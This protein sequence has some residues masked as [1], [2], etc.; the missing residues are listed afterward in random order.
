MR[1]GTMMRILT[2][3]WWAMMFKLF[4]LAENRPGRFEEPFQAIMLLLA[5]GMCVITI[6]AAFW[7]AHES[8]LQDAEVTK[9]RKKVRS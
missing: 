3:P 9:L 5:V 6:P 2:I 4:W 1:K 7:A 8:D